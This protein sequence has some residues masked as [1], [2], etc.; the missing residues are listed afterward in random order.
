MA[1][2][3]LT[4]AQSAPANSHVGLAREICAGASHDGSC[5]IGAVEFREFLTWGLARSTNG[6]RCEISTLD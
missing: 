2:A 6:I 1:G 3:F 4:R 5:P